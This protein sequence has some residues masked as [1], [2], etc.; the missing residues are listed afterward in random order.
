MAG[1]PCETFSSA[2]YWTP[3]E[4]EGEEVSKKSWPRPLRDADR[5]WGLPGLTSKELK[6]LWQ[7]S[8]FAMQTLLILAWFLVTGGCFVSEHPFPPKEEWKVSVFRTPLARMLLQ[9]PEVDLKCFYQGEW[10]AGSTKPTGL[11]T[12]RLPRIFHS[13]W[14]HRDPTPRHER[15]AAIGVDASGKFKTAKLKEYPKGFSAGLSQTIFDELQRRFFDKVKF[16]WQLQ[17]QMRPLTGSKGPFF[18][19][20]PSEMVLQ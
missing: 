19:A 2:R 5:P 11:M 9:F 16:V 4:Q 12:V 20:A 6:Q 18:P 17:F 8:Q 15:S 1:S 7:G 14:R 10:G 3:P 13:M